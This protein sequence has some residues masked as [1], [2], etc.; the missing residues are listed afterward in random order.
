MPIVHKKYIRRL[1]ASVGIYIGICIYI[2]PRNNISCK[3]VRYEELYPFNHKDIRDLHRG[4]FAVQQFYAYLYLHIQINK[5][6]L[7]CQ[8][9]TQSTSVTNGRSVCQ[10]EQAMSGVLCTF[11]CKFH[12][13]P[14]MKL[15]QQSATRTHLHTHAA[16]LYFHGRFSLESK[17]GQIGM[18]LQIV[19]F[20][21]HIFW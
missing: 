15:G 8:R 9:L 19:V 2:N 6:Y 12:K 4:S 17:F 10:T 16:H 18:Q 14:H 11:F 3:I 1:L 7:F 13:M 20:R 21:Y 5:I